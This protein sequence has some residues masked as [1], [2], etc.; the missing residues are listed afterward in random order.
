[1]L[2][3][4][5]LKQNTF[6]FGTVLL[7]VSTMGL[8]TALAKLGLISS[9]RS[10]RTLKWSDFSPIRFQIWLEAEPVGISLKSRRLLV[11]SGC[12]ETEPMILMKRE[13]KKKQPSDF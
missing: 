2:N 13:R 1:M 10:S 7:S 11:W 3:Q 12:Q 5:I 6:S 9:G 4:L 8:K